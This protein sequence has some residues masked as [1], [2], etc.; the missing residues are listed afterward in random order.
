MYRQPFAPTIRPVVLLWL[1]ALALGWTA[2]SYAQVR[3]LTTDVPTFAGAML[4]LRVETPERSGS[5]AR[6]YPAGRFQISTASTAPTGGNPTRSG[7]EGL[8]IASILSS[9]YTTSA[10]LTSKVTLAVDPDTLDA[11]YSLFDPHYVYRS[12]DYSSWED[13]IWV[14]SP[15][16]GSRDVTGTFHV[17]EYDADATETGAWITVR[18][19]QTVIGDAVRIEYIVTNTGTLSHSVG[20]RIAID[21]TFGVSNLDG[22]EIL[23][24]D[25]TTITNETTLTAAS[26]TMPASWIAYDNADSPNVVLRGI[27]NCEE[28]TDPGSA[29]YAGGLPD[30]IQFGLVSDAAVDMQYAFTPTADI[31]LLDNDWAYAVYW[32]PDTLPAGTSRRYVTWYGLGNSAADYSSP[33]ALM[34]FAPWSLVRHD[35]DDSST[36]DVTESYYLSDSQG[37]SPFPVAVYMDNYGSASLYDS[38]CRVRLPEGLALAAGETSSKSAGIVA[39]NEIADVS[40]DI[41]AADARPGVV[42]IKFSGPRAKS[43]TRNLNIPAVPVMNPLPDS[44]NGLEMISV[45]YEFED[46]DAESVFASLGELLAGGPA[47]LIRYNPTLSEYRW[48]PDS[49]V[50]TITPGVGYWLVNRNRLTVTMPDDATAV[51]SDE[52]YL[53]SLKAGWNMIGNPFTSAVRLDSVRVTNDSGADWSLDE[54]SARNMLVPTAFA[55][56]TAANEYTWETDPSE[57]YLDPYRGYWLL[58]REDLVLAFTPPTG[59]TPSS[60][61]KPKSSKPVVAA[62]SGTN[63]SFN[64]GVASSG[65]NP[66]SRGLGVRSAAVRGLDRFDVPEPPASIKKS[67]SYLQAAFYPGASAVGTPYL[68]DTRAPAQ[69]AQE[70]NLIVKTN[71]ANA[72]VAVTWPS[73]QT[74]P[75]GL[76][77][78]LIDPVSGEKRYMRTTNSYVFR[79]GSTASERLLKVVVQPR[80]AQSLA[81]TSVQS[82]QTADGAAL[83]Y[84]LS[85]DATVDV[86]VRN[87]AGLVIGTVASGQAATAG[88]NTLVWNGRNSRGSK[89]PGGR[90]LC[91]ITARSPLTGQSMSVV[92]PLQIQR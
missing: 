49:Y 6:V 85:S 74:L 84:T 39:H 1:C 70:W 50:T 92:S 3:N 89:V 61:A 33:Y 77:A 42:Q 82:L 56:D 80:P 59:Y 75:S 35:G 25:G 28:A 29:T 24:P 60:S 40:W 90:Y 83:T 54:A 62:S 22:S 51:P 44:E 73:L 46:A 86:R 9:A 65:L 26:G 43:V 57:A 34:A 88:T 79:T 71:A 63:W 81:V 14:L 78:T 64:L 48:F 67:A 47:S 11:E 45:P 21:G 7:D 4:K 66:V 16:I 41:S 37:R 23:L 15:S 18:Q 8:N 19:I 13:N 91:E 17:P 5:A 72:E 31:S 2:A 53:V 38:T 27:V 87:I 68:V 32:A 10:E 55:Y 12:G 36:S 69:G 76:V 30:S 52:S 58:A 20:L